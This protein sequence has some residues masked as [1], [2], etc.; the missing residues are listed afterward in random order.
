MRAHYETL[1]KHF[2][3]LLFTFCFNLLFSV[4]DNLWYNLV[5]TCLNLTV[6]TLRKKSFIYSDF[7]DDPQLITFTNYFLA[8]I[9]L[10]P[11]SEWHCSM[12]VL[13]FCCHIV[14]HVRW[15]YWTTTVWHIKQSAFCLSWI[16]STITKKSLILNN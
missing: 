1:K 14:A 5:K 9:P 6:K 10:T 16:V 12:H 11:W 8:G 13:Y 3:V 4:H 15:C 7:G 2:T